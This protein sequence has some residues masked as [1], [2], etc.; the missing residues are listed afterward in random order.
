M[1]ILDR[2]NLRYIIS[3]F[4]KHITFYSRYHN[5]IRNL[6][7]SEFSLVSW[8][9][10]FLS[11][12]FPKERL[13]LP[14][15]LLTGATELN[16]NRTRRM[17]FSVWNLSA[18]DSYYYIIHILSQRALLP[19]TMAVEYGGS[20]RFLYQ[21]GRRDRENNA[22]IIIFTHSIKLIFCLLLFLSAFVSTFLFYERIHK[23]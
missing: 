18:V 21:L 7:I 4:C 15:R 12:N 3:F 5:L 8:S 11:D 20:N 13:L 19:I 9:H 22:N 2:S 1:E 6:K 14:P 10:R 16:E 23:V 17:A